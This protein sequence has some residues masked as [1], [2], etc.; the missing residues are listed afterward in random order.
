MCPGSARLCSV[1]M[2]GRG[3]CGVPLA[4]PLGV[5]GRESCARRATSLLAGAA[6]GVAVC[7]SEGICAESVLAGVACEPFGRDAGT[8]TSIAPDRSAGFGDAVA[9]SS[10]GLR[11]GLTRFT[12]S[13][14][15]TL[16]RVMSYERLHL[17]LGKLI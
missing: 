6:G 11:S 14:R 13:G 16:M 12:T 3:G 2:G 4:R 5:D 7:W 8:S 1:G 15:G 17:I 9:R 10:P